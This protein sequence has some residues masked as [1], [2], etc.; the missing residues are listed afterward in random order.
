MSMTL[1][2]VQ[3]LNGLQLGVLLFLFFCG[4]NVLEASQPSQA[5]RLAPPSA[6]GAALGVYNTLQ[7]LGI[8]AGGALGGWVA[9]HMGTQGLF[10]GCTALM[11]L[12]LVVAWGVPFV[13]PSAA[14]QAGHAST[15][16]EPATVE[17]PAR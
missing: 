17:R 6:R 14:T 3:T 5:S 10:L 16:S 15:G 13:A 4:F 12:W 2:Y 7:S 1:L 11:A 9:K 8:F